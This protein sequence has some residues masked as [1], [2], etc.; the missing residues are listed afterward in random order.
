MEAKLQQV[1][2]TSEAQVKEID[3]LKKQVKDLSKK[4]KESDKSLKE[5]EKEIQNYKNVASDF[6]ERADISEM[7]VQECE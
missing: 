4:L 6:A 7:H 5:R 2:A 3:E 1:T